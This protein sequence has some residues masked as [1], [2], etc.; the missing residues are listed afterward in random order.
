MTPKA[1]SEPHC[2]LMGYASHRVAEAGLSHLASPATV[3]TTQHSLTLYSIQLGLNLAWMP[4]FFV[5][6]RPIAATIDILALAGV[7][8]YLTYLWSEIDEVA[9]WCQAPYLGWLGFATYLCVGAGYLNNWDLSA[10]QD[11]PLDRK[12]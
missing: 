10:R 11:E 7:N 12:R 3:A 4:L 2:R 1:N 6:K 5:A 9:A 8:G